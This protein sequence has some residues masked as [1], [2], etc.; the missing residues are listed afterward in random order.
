LHPAASHAPREGI[1]RLTESAAMACSSRR[2][3]DRAPP[4]WPG[5]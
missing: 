4:V 1:P 3:P 5:R 2:G